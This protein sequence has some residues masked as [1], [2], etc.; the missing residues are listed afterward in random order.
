MPR[1]RRKQASPE[2]RRLHPAILPAAAVTLTFI[3]R[4][5][6]ILEMRGQPFS[7]ISS[8]VVDSYYYHQWALDILNN[9]FWGTDVFFLRPL[10]PYLLALVY[11]VFGQGTL[12]VQLLQ[13]LMAAASCLLL[14][15]STRRMFDRTAGLIAAF[16]FG[17]TGILVFYTGAL[18]YVELT[19][20]LALLHVWLV[21]TAGRT[22]WR[23][24]LAGLAYGLLVICRPELLVL[25]PFCLVILWRR[26]TGLR[27]LALLA[28]SAAVVIAAVPVRN[29]AVAGE[30]VLFTAHSGINFYYANNPEADGTWHPTGELERTSGFSHRRLAEA[31]RSVDGE[32][33]SWS[34]AS[35]HWLRRGLGFVFGRPGR[36]LQLV[37]RKLLLFIASYEVPNNYYPETARPAS[38]AL[39]LAFIPFGLVLALAVAGMVRSWRDRRRCW[40]AWLLVAGLLFSSLAFYVLSRLRTPV[41]PFL[42]MFAGCGL[43]G[44]A[45]SVRGRRW[46]RAGLD[47]AVVAVVLAA[48]LLVPVDRARYSSQAWTQLGNTE[49]ERKHAG[50]AVEA[51]SRALEYNPANPSTRY[52][53]VSAWAGMGRREEAAAELQRLAAAGQDPANRVLVDLG[54]ARVA[55]AF[56]DFPEA[57]RGYR[58]VLAADPASI[59]ARYLL[60]LV[61][62][63]MDSLARAEEELGRAVELDP[64]NA[65]AR[66]ALGLV[67]SRL[68]RTRSP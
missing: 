29:L 23:W 50:A 5:W 26:K 13:A 36:F 2:R 28:V 55:I 40:P 68:G 41:I 58:A 12:A 22:W 62:V 63:S 48:S 10:Y 25:A 66:E 17:L 44:V 67:R 37:G 33:L 1:R 19:I 43:A 18:L 30:P 60:G 8:Q 56:R 57:V 11:A 34:R 14:Y 20:L 52:S 3:V 61:Y 51:L 38:T 64:A 45:R 4:L 53:L 49:L 46:P 35:N 6:F 15:D 21:L 54:R 7:A 31:A 39:K 9:G 27:N 42:L 47:A 24:L 59:E 32:V 16:G 65:D